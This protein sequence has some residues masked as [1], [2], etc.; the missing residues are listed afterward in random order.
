[1]FCYCI[2]A[3]K[4][5]LKSNT[6]WLTDCSYLTYL[7]SNNQSLSSALHTSLFHTE[8]VQHTRTLF[9]CRWKR[10]KT[11]GSHNNIHHTFVI[12]MRSVCSVWLQTTAEF[13]NW[14]SQ[15]WCPVFHLFKQQR[16]LL[17][18][19]RRTVIL[20]SVE[21][22]G[23]RL[24]SFGHWQDTIYDTCHNITIVTAAVA[25]QISTLLTDCFISEWV[26]E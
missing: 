23:P 3:L 21:T 16:P 26:S 6:E 7:K 22:T 24:Q 14:L 15:C 19:E 8:N 13:G 4:R 2:T 20:H 9:L 10:Y 17:S 18:T 5:L 11:H 25:Q 12:I 1:L